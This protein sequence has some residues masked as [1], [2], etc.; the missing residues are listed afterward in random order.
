MI[1]YPWQTQ[2]QMLLNSAFTSI[3]VGSKMRLIPGSNPTVHSIFEFT[4]CRL[5]KNPKNT[6]KLNYC[7][8]VIKTSS[9]GV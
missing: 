1:I 6:R 9:F 8:A 7:R 4:V 5:V 2:P 3:T